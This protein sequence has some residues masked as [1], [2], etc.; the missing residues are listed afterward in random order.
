M[1]VELQ[2]QTTL[3]RHSPISF[4]LLFF[5][6]PHGRPKLVVGPLS[7]SPSSN[8]L[9]NNIQMIQI[10][11]PWLSFLC[12]N[13]RFH[14][15]RVFFFFWDEFFVHSNCFFFFAYLVVI[16]NIGSRFSTKSHRFLIFDRL[17]RV[18]SKTQ[19]LIRY[20]PICWSVLYL[21]S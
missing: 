3:L 14:I 4:S 5:T 13:S 12:D 10:P 15:H 20:L 1:D 11:K 18:N 16:G 19:R 17:D 9:C 2:T 7:V 6:P 8:S 21:V